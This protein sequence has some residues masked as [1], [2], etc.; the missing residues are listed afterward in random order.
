MSVVDIS[1]VILAKNEEKYIASTLEM[2][3]NQNIDK[4]DWNMLSENTNIFETDTKSI[5]ENILNKAILL[6]GLIN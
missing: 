5:N 3:F 6:D 2:I 1:I 4:I